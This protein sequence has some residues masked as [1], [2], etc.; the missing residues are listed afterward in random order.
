MLISV[1]SP[2]GRKEAVSSLVQT[3]LGKA[4]S[5]HKLASS[6]DTVFPGLVPSHQPTA[7]HVKLTGP[8][9]AACSGPN[10][11]LLRLH[12]WHTCSFFPEAELRTYTV[13]SGRVC[14]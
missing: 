14:S 11:A 3:A 12:V 7:F 10:N 2:F 13:V 6:R 8:D 5:W 1:T 9:V 4:V